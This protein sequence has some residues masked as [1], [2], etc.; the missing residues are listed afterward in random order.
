[1]ERK[2]FTVID[3]TREVIVLNRAGQNAG[4][5]NVAKLGGVT[6]PRAARVLKDA[7]AAGLIFTYANDYRSH[8]A[9][10]CYS[11]TTA[12]RCVVEIIETESL[13]T[14]WVLGDE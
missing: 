3:A 4:K 8:I 9:R 6:P 2:T 5:C 11:A 12:G 14:N 10:C 1:M 13:K 7:V